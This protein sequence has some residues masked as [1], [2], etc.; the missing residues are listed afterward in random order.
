[1]DFDFEDHGSVCILTP[2]TAAAKAWTEEN[3]P[4][5][6]RWA[7]DIAIGPRYVGPI[8]AGVEEAGLTQ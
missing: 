8:L 4:S 2:I 6:Q 7:G 3:I 5:A 1:M